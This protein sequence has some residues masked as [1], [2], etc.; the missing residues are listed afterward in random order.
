MRLYIFIIFLCLVHVS[1]SQIEKNGYDEYEFDVHKKLIKELYS[2]L[3]IKSIRKTQLDKALKEHIFTG[4][5]IKNSIIKLNLYSSYYYYKKDLINRLKVQ[6]KL[7]I[8]YS[9]FYVPYIRPQENGYRTEV[10][11]VSFMN[12]AKQGIRIKGTQPISFS[13]HHNPIADFDP[14]NIKKQLHTSDIK[15]KELIYLT[16]DYRQVG[17]GGDNSWSKEGLADPQ[18][19][20]N[21]K[22]CDYSFTISPL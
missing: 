15:P 21:S 22:K 16:L 8:H 10:R 7:V 20:I 13:A 4:N 1:F 11:N 12:K 2:P 17:V 19:R 9:D 18:Y 5:P 14:R 3:T 6:L